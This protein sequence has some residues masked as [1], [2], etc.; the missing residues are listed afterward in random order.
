[1]DTGP[2][3]LGW[4]ADFSAKWITTERPNNSFEIGDDENGVLESQMMRHRIS[5]GS[6]L[7]HETFASA[8]LGHI[9][10][11]ARFFG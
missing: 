6:R 7:V 3:S 9:F 2:I 11:I 1:M 4:F 10:N 8:K 5:K